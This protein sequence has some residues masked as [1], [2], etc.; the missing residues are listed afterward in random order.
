[1][2]RTK[3]D[4]RAKSDTYVGWRAFERWVT[5]FEGHFSRALFEGTFRWGLFKFSRFRVREFARLVWR[6]GHLRVGCG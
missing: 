1:M 2:L 4:S 5:L 3:T 6:V